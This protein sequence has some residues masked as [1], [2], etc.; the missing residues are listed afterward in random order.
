LLLGIVAPL[1]VPPLFQLVGVA[2]EIVLKAM[3]ASTS[4]KIS[5]FMMML[6]LFG[7]QS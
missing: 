1:N 3:T 6:V 4:I 7:N 5:L 2:E